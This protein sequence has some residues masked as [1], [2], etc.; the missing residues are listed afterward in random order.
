MDKEKLKE[1]FPTV[2]SLMEEINKYVGKTFG[3]IDVN[4][5]LSSS[6]KGA[7]GQIIEEGIFHYRINSDPSSDFDYLGVELKTCGVEKKKKGD[8]SAKERLPLC[9]INYNKLIHENFEDSHVFQKNKEL[10]IVIYLYIKDAPYANF[11]ILECIDYKIPKNDLEI[12]KNDFEKIKR[13]VENGRAHELSESLTTYLSACTSGSGHG[14]TISQP[15]SP[16]RA[17]PR[18]F[19]LK[20]SYLKYVFDKNINKKRV[21]QILAGINS[22]NANQSF[23]DFII[24]KLSTY[25]GMSADEICNKLNINN[26]CRKDIYAYLVS[27]IFNVKNINKT[28]EFKKANIISKTLRVEKSFSVKEGISFP[29]FDFVKLANDTFEQSEFYEIIETSKFLFNIFLRDKNEKEDIYRYFGSFFYTF[30]ITEA[31]ECCRKVFEETKNVLLSGDI[32][33]H[34]KKNKKG[35]EIRYNN[36]PKSTNNKMFHVRPHS[37]DHTDTNPIPVSEIHTGEKVYSK[38]CFWINAS[39]MK[40]TVKDFINSQNLNK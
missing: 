6:N 22:L 5:R 18:K 12:I 31:E 21:E 32:I 34:I 11:P 27:Q 39:Y 36:F 23:E 35:K 38:M 19:A 25:K 3:S 26:S 37:S 8:Y 13:Y 28:T 14:Y 33:H 24:N 16:I 29:A 7:F 4:K 17:K 2:Q 10:L 40:R 30:P 15:N 1:N 9:N 20:N